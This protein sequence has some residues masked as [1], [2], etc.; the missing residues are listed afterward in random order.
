M[1]P[2]S[3]F[4]FLRFQGRRRSVVEWCEG[5]DDRLHLHVTGHRFGVLGGLQGEPGGARG[6][7]VGPRGVWGG[8]PGRFQGGQEAHLKI[9]KNTFLGGEFCIRLTKYWCFR[10]GVVFWIALLQR[11]CYCFLMTFR[12]MKFANPWG[13]NIGNPCVFWYFS[14]LHV[15]DFLRKWW[16]KIDF[17]EV[18]F[19]ACVEQFWR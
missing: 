10:F 5:T 16:W 11:R 6:L 15:E 13:E 12:G 9:T 7:G 4:S 1:P 8:V 2:T 14:I 17:W 18:N 3:F 19:E